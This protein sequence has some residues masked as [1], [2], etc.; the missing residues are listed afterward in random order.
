M[1]AAELLA[2]MKALT[3]KA[4]TVC[5]VPSP[6]REAIDR[7]PEEGIGPAAIN[8]ILAKHGQPEIGEKRLRR[9]Y[10]VCKRG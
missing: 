8:K 6:F 7:A 10:A 3:V 1:N 4:C 5:A 9:H 2:E